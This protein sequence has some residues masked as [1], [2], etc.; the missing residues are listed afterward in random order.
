MQGKLDRQRKLACRECGSVFTTTHPSKCFCEAS[1]RIR[2]NNRR[3]QRGMELYDFAME[4]RYSREHEKE[5][6]SV[7]DALCMGY[8]DRDKEVRQGRKS[9]YSFEEARDSLPRLP[10]VADG[11]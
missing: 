2:F 9:W 10:G 7:L 11:R 4:R 6:R 3:M 8:R 1:C 5:A